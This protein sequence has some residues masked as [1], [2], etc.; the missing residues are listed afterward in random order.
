M[1]QIHENTDPQLESQSYVSSFY[2]W[3]FALIGTILKLSS[4]IKYDRFGT[5]ETS[6]EAITPPPYSLGLILE[7]LVVFSTIFF[8]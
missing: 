2:C 1:I 4:V 6:D 7:G 8:R 5:L 3:P